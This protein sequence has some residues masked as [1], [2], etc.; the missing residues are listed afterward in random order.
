[1]KCL[2]GEWLMPKVTI[3]KIYIQTCTNCTDIHPR[4]SIQQ[5]CTNLFNRCALIQQT[6]ITLHIYIYIAV[7]L[8]ICR[9]MKVWMS[10]YSWLLSKE[11][12]R[13]YIILWLMPKVTYREWLRPKVTI[14][15]FY[16][17][18]L[19]YINPQT[20]THRHHCCFYIPMHK[21]ADIL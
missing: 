15:K 3:M 16:S 19:H 7:V 12:S 11:L 9:C 2:Y 18:D 4:T 6:S 8:H 1:M 5:T 10:L 20:C 13:I 17:V 21:G 14:V